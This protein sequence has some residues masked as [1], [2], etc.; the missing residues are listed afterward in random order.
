MD[1]SIYADTQTHTIHS[2]KKKKKKEKKKERKST[3]GEE[4]LSRT[5]H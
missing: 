2:C 3:C 1:R 4:S 5:T